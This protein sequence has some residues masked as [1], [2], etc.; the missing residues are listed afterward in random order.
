MP[1]RLLLLMK[2]IA[3]GLYGGDYG[4]MLDEITA[5]GADHV[6]LV[7][8]WKQHD[9][10]ATKL[11][12]FDGT[13]PDDKLRDVIRMA[14]ARALKVFLFPII[15][16]EVRK[17]GEW[18]GTL[19]PDDVGAWWS[20]YETFVLHY[21]TIAADEGVE[22][23]A[24]GSELAS[25]ESWQDRWFHLIS[26]VKGV[27]RG[28]LLYSANWDH[29]EHVTFWERVDYVGVTAYNE[30][31]RKPGASE[32]ELAHAWE[33]VRDRLVAFARR[34]DRPLVVTEIGY[35]SQ[36]GAALHP[37]DYTLKS[38]VN[39]EEQRRCYAAFV[40]AWR[41]EPALEGVFWWNWWGAGGDKDGSYTPKGKPA[42][43]VLRNYFSASPV[44]D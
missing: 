5:V 35:V 24:I 40:A 16:V 15:E 43:R 6:S 38:K 8:S 42:E 36:E 2:G 7:V 41:G 12:P 31:T 25:T 9:V 37:W 44:H 26:K 13:L 20:A 3:L 30:L 19:R 1:L 11:A 18:R 27:F 34:V 29:Y 14:R 4:H 23:Y 17:P 21:A 10:R 32:A 28:K 33:E 22:L 39:L